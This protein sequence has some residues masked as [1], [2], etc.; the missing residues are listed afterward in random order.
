MPLRTAFVIGSSIANK[1]WPHCGQLMLLDIKMASERGVIGSQ[2]RGSVTKQ[3]PS[4]G[5]PGDGPM[6][7]S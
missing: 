1:A 6:L 2:A 7:A 4:E 3:S 5:P